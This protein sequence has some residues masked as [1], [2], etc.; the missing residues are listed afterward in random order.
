LR[1]KLNSVDQHILHG[2]YTESCNL[3]KVYRSTAFLF[4][5]SFL[6]LAFG[7]LERVD[8]FYTMHIGDH[9]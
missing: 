1:L 6:I 2:L 9:T 7:Q 4:I 5:F 3:G 8:S